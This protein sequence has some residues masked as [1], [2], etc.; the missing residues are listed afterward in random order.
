MHFKV[1]EVVCVYFV[2]VH[3][4]LFLL[5]KLKAPFY[6]IGNL[7]S[8]LVLSGL[9]IIVIYSGGIKAPV[10]AWFLCVIVSAFWYANRLSG[11]IWFVITALDVLFIFMADLFEVLPAD[12]MPEEAYAFYAGVML[13]GIMFYYFVVIITY[14]NWKD[15]AVK[16]MNEQHQELLSNHEELQHQNEEIA[17][18]K[19]LLNDRTERIEEVN[20]KLNGSISYAS[21][22]QQSILSKEE[23]LQNYF[24]DAFV[25]WKPRDVV[26]GDFYWMCDFGKGIKVL[27]CIDCTGHGVPGSFL[28]IMANDILNE[29][30]HYLKM[31]DPRHL[32]IF[33][34]QNIQRLTSK[35]EK[36]Y[37]ED[38]MDVSIIRVNENE[39]EVEFAG[40]KQNLYRISD[41]ELTEYKGDKFS[42]GG[43]SIRDKRFIKKSF[44]YQKDDLLFL[45]SDGYQDQFGGKNDKKFMRKQYKSNLLNNHYLPLQTQKAEL[46]KAFNLWKGEERQTDDVL[47][48]GIKL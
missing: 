14:E 43:R 37:I 18:Q 48:V 12:Q 46:S 10:I 13:L 23:E 30:A 32:I 2:A 11:I 34:D 29:A 20:L 31:S 38:G 1:G 15:K 25:Y 9:S 45:Q 16:K 3:C 42:V 6:I 35:R 33:L 40:A 26:G 39:G 24:A 17:A 41:G 36:G 19:E 22:I 47:V 4:L 8:F 7:F 21:R 28:T 5:L 27:A 44:E